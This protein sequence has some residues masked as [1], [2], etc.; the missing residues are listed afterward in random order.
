MVRY[1]VDGDDTWY[2]SLVYAGDLF[3][4][5]KE[6][7]DVVIARKLEA[8]E[9]IDHDVRCDMWHKS[10]YN[11]VVGCYVSPDEVKEPLWKDIEILRNM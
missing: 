5:R 3:N 7:Q 10:E 8:I 1:Q 4:S 11:A 6:L 9:K 2:N